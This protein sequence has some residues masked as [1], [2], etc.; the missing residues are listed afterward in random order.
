MRNY[1]IVLLAIA[2]PLSA[3]EARGTIL[4]R[5]SDPSGAVIG[6]A[7][8]EA[9]NVET[10]VRFTLNTNRSGDYTFPLLLPG[11]Y[12]VKV[13]QSGFKTYSRTGVAVRVNDQVT[14][15]ITMEVGQSSQSVLV[16][17]ESPLL[18]TSAATIG[19][20]VDSR[21]IMELPLKDGMVLTM[22]TLAPG[23]I[24]TPE[25]A[26]YVRPFDTSSPSTMSIDGTR[27]G[28]NQFMMDGSANMQGGQVAYSPPP[29]VVDEFKVQAATFDAGSGFFGGASINMSLKSG[30]NSIHGQVYYFMQNPV[31]TANK[32][33]RLAAGKPQFRLYRWGDS[34]S[35]PVR[36]PKLYDG[37]NKTFF[38][39]GYEGIWSYDPSPWIVEAVPSAAMRTGDLSRLPYQIY[40]PY[41]ITPAAN[42]LFSRSPLPGNI[43]PASR[44]SPVARNLGGLFDAPNQAGT[45]DGTNNY[46]RGRNS[47]DT[48]WNHIVRIDHNISEKQR[49]YIRTNFTDLQRPQNIKH[50]NAVGDN[51]Y[52]YN[53]G[54]SFDDVYS[55]KPTLFI[56]TRYTLTRFITGNTPYQ[57]DWDLAGAGFSS[58]F[59]A[60]IKGV[61]PRYVKLPNINIAG[62]APLGGANARNNTATDIHEAAA[63]VT[64]IVG[65]HNLRYGFAYRTYI[66]NTFNLGNSS[67]L[68]NFDTT[69]TRGP[70]SSAA[71]APM[72]QS[73]AAF[74]YGLPG[75]G[76]FPISDSYSEISKVP[77]IFFHDDWKVNRKL[78]LSLGLRYE[79][80][81]PVVERFDRSVRGF[82]QSV[83]SPIQA[84]AQA[85]Y[86]RA[87]IPQVPAAQFRV[88]GGLTFAGIGGEPRTLWKTSQNLIMPRIGFALSLTP[89]TVVRGGYGVFFDALGV[90][91]VHVNQTGFS[92]NTDLIPSLDNGLNF[93]A[94]LSNPFPG[95]F[96]QPPRS[97]GGLATNLGQNINFF[98][99]NTTSSYMQ[100]WQFAVQRQLAASSLVEVSYVGNRGTRMQVG[101]EF[102]AVPEQYLSTSATRD[103]NVIN[104]LGAQVANPFY[105]LLPRT[106]LAST[107]VPRNQ[108]L[109]PY[110]QFTSV[111]ANQ[112]IGYTWYHS[113]QVRV[114]RRFSKGL[115]SSLSY[116]WSKT[117]EALGFLNA[118]DPYL[119]EVISSQDRPHRLTLT[120]L[121]ELPFGKGRLIPGPSNRVLGG[122]IGGWQA[123]GI[124]TLQSGAAL[125]F[126]NSIFNGDLDN[127]RLPGDKR[128]VNR[129]FNTDAGFERINALQLA[130]NVRRLNT[131]F[132]A[133]RADGPNNWDMS[134]L[135]NTRLSEKVQMQFRAEAIN[136][137][138]HPQFTAPNTTPANTAFGAV[139]GEFAWPR[140]IQF[141]LKMLF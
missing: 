61:D 117:M 21:T 105:P 34:I 114:E 55:V 47:Q 71:G 2:A 96:I 59:I 132:A 90:T 41:T 101:R 1:L 103:Q 81:T 135:K 30:T 127:I 11:A 140:V 64:H 86:A 37:R 13:E 38:M 91:N 3:Q 27:S 122:F 95:G 89:K 57:L 63:N 115:S 77:A 84:Q 113:A 74:L 75:G 82:D 112:N 31:F 56:N 65:A 139:T 4:G 100:R 129:W 111:T 23:V 8:V 97:S 131:R 12:T 110:P 39:Y 62:Y 48:Y 14:I 60:Q 121:Y 130:S 99:P 108:L 66:R 67:G 46:A 6:G 94:S 35:G 26:G 10:G 80:P 78:T 43:V 70:L 92:Q 104:L 52:R 119:E 98:D 49:F 25:S 7:K 42:G 58:G 128:S 123:Q 88:P 83:A 19:Y 138:N 85:N 93:I 72:G 53:K 24:F 44:I 69:W 109:R 40:D 33:F 133:V 79:R 36:I 18:D 5:V 137:L 9:A 124:F 15:D 45:V 120:W 28:S 134:L 141:G 20:V 16:S 102:N 22:A 125:G 116:T 126:G 73:Y 51:F 107:T 87:P 136:A 50:N 106:N 54:F 29:G 76:N 17:A 32:Y 68:L 118:T